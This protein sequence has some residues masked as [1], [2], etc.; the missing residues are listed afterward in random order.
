MS[1]PIKV[2][3]IWVVPLNQ[4][5]MIA[6]KTGTLEDPQFELCSHPE[7]VFNIDTAL[8][9]F[10]G[11]D[12]TGKWI[13]QGTVPWQTHASRRVIIKEG[14]TL[15]PDRRISKNILSTI[16]ERLALLHNPNR[17]AF[18]HEGNVYLGNVVGF[19]IGNFVQV[20]FQTPGQNDPQV[21]T[22]LDVPICAP[23][24]LSPRLRPTWKLKNGRPDT[25]QGRGL[26][27]LTVGTAAGNI[28]Q[29]TLDNMKKL[30]RQLHE[31]NTMSL[32]D[33]IT[34]GYVPPPVLAPAVPPTGGAA[35][36]QP[37]GTADTWLARG[38]AP[39]TPN[40][41]TLAVGTRFLLELYVN[42]QKLEGY[43]VWAKIVKDV[44]PRR[45]RPS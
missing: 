13:K 39:S 21:R 40:T 27:S 38:L 29:E 2:Y 18:A 43:P 24:I 14:F 35:P 23:N 31:A 22:T 15:P 5:D 7:N 33:D 26:Q 37:H 9:R 30:A 11:D 3:P 16:L 32:C 36:P 6:H 42:N 19:S 17:L 12:A 20:V 45:R 10:Q 41:R 44:V 4:N 28:T 34:G 25:A 1:E 8:W